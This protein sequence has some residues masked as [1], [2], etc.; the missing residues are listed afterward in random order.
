MLSPLPVKTVITVKQS[1]FQN[2][3]MIQAT[4][5]MDCR[6]VDIQ[7]LKVSSL[8]LMIT[9]SPRAPRAPTEHP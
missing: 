7:P 2:Q 8:D 1:K 6:Q 5:I 4:M 3:S 9:S